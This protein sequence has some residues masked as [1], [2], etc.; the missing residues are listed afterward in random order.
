M[1][2]NPGTLFYYKLKQSAAKSEEAFVQRHTH[3]ALFD[4]IWHDFIFSIPVR[5]ILKT[6][7]RFHPQSIR[8]M[9]LNDLTYIPFGLTPNTT[10]SRQVIAEALHSTSICLVITLWLNLA[11]SRPSKKV[12]HC[13]NC[14]TTFCDAI[15]YN[16]CNTTTPEA[17]YHLTN[18][19]MAFYSL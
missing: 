6:K 4:T 12:V 9:K 16:I 7:S 14:N 19:A 10:I 13:N 3:S 18:I 11:A 8:F 15:H 1:R 2:K 5:L 17:I